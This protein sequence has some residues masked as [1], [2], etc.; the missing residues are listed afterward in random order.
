MKKK[1]DRVINNSIWGLLIV[2]AISLFSSVFT[3]KNIS[4]LQ[5]DLQTMYERDFIGQNSMQLVRVRVLMVDRDVAK[6][7]ILGDIAGR[8][9][10]AESI[11]KDE[12]QIRVLMT[13]SARFFVSG[14]ISNTFRESE[15]SLSHYFAIVN[16]VTE[17]LKKADMGEAGAIL[18]GE[19]KTSLEKLDHLLEQLD[20]FKVQHDLKLYKRI[21]NQLNLSLVV[22]LLVLSGTIIIRLHLYRKR[23]KLTEVGEDSVPARQTGQE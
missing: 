3:L 23:A 2:T 7:F 8:R 18:A 19:M 15:N 22:T 5:H 14:A 4:S 17:L 6:M 12:E 9:I 10:M 21:V 16:R 20:D 13:N 1:L 11:L